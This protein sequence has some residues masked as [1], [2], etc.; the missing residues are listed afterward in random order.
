MKL[1]SSA[2]REGE[3]IPKQ[4]TGDGADVSPPLAW[5]SVPEGVKSFALICDDP[6]APRGTWVHWTLYDLPPEARSLA[7][8]TPRTR[9]LANGARQGLNDSGKIGYAGPYP[10]SGTHRYYFKLYALDARVN[11]DPGLTKAHLLQAM[12]GHILAEAQL[13][14]RYSRR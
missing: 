8:N 6:D 3:S 13:M 5:D 10:P 1:T 7:E 14:G 11:R 12:Q 9:T 2:F 4:Y